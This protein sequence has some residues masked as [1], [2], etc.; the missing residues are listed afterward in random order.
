MSSA[1]LSGLTSLFLENRQF[2]QGRSYTFTFSFI[3][4]G[5]KTATIIK[6][7]PEAS[8]KQKFLGVVETPG[9]HFSV[10]RVFFR[11]ATKRITVASND[12]CIDVFYGERS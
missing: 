7:R 12:G 8:T 3:R 9:S 6:C 1:A 10:F 5:F 4:F 11:P 2:L